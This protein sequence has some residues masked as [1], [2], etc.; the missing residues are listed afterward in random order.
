MIAWGRQ[1][2]GAWS[3][4][5]F[6]ERS[7]APLALARIGYGLLL[8]GWTA[9]LLPDVIDFFGPTPAATTTIGGW[10]WSVFEV[11]A[12]PA[13]LWTGYV[14]LIVAALALTVGLFTRL[15]AIVAFVLL[16]SFQRQ[17]VWILNSGDLLV[18]H[19]GLFLAL[20][21]AGGA[22]SVDRWLRARDRFWEPEPRPIWPL[23]LI[24]VQLAAMYLFSVWAKA[25]GDTWAEG[26]AVGY[27][28]RIDDLTRFAVPDVITEQ[29]VI[30]NL[31]TYGTLAIELAIPLLVWN[32]RLRPWVLGLGAVMHV[33]IDLTITVGFF[34]YAV[35]VGYLAFIPSETADR[36]VDR[37]RI[38]AAAS[39]SGSADE[40]AA[41][42]AG[43]DTGSVEA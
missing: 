26:T 13:A 3:T 39:G 5:W 28:L 14:V 15:A 8:L 31:L 40:R 9:T 23:R 32:R 33:A 27:A 19:L 38:G 21:A 43:R 12:S 42:G 16:L 17:N 2:V 36:L 4:F 20:G 18:R 41:Q 25:R 10:R 30:V 37:L 7:V 11:A 6:D 24:Q 34:S 35:F 29:L 1:V 22:L